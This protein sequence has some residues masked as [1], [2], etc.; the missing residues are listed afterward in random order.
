MD[1]NSHRRPF[2]FACNCLAAAFLLSLVLAACDFEPSVTPLVVINPDEPTVP[3]PLESPAPDLTQQPIDPE[4]P[5][6]PSG[7]G[8]LE[9][10]ECLTVAGVEYC[11]GQELITSGGLNLRDSGSIAGEIVAVLPCG[12]TVTIQGM[13]QA[14]GADGHTWAPVVTSTGQSGWAAVDVL[15]ASPPTCALP[16]VGEL[17]PGAG[18]GVFLS[19][20]P[21]EENIYDL[22]F[23]WGFGNNTFA[24]ENKCVWY[25]RTS[26]MHSGLDFG[27][28]YNSELSWT[29]S[30]DGEVVGVNGEGL[31]LGAGPN[32][33]VIESDGFY[34]LYGHT[35]D[36]EP[37]VEIGQTVQPGELIG[38]S[39]NPGG[40]DDAGNDHLHFEIR[41]TD[42]RTI[43]VNPLSFM[44]DDQQSELTEYFAGD[45]EGEDAPMSLGYYTLTILAECFEE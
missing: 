26:G 17:Y 40:A 43:V 9:A 38:Y 21:F 11:A 10:P 1:R 14:S 8:T 20:L 19:D 23:W 39:G 35:S 34:F 32:S 42:D 28:P 29:G 44:G 41:P 2:G 16:S 31:N 5:A 37:S 22:D 24:Q 13:P 25:E 6:T 30:E 33:I 12:A 27:L 4:Q 3:Q 7:F 18:E 36:D 45:Y 15:D